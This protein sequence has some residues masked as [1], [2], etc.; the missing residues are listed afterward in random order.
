MNGKSHPTFGDGKV[1]CS[2]IP[3]L[4]MHCSAAFHEQVLAAFSTVEKSK[5]NV[6]TASPRSSYHRKR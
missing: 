5:I 3:A 6:L 2:E 1:C 4:D